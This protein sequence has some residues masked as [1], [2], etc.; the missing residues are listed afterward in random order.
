MLADNLVNL[1]H[2]M[3]FARAQIEG[4]R[5]CVVFDGKIH[6]MEEVLHI[7]KIPRGVRAETS[8]AGFQPF[9]KS[10]NWPNGQ[11]RARDV[12]QAQGDSWDGGKHH[13]LF[14]S[15]LSDAVAGK[16][17]QRMGARNRNL[18]RP[19]VAERGLEIDHAPHA[20]PHR[21]LRDNGATDHVRGAVFLPVIRI[22]VG[23]RSVNDNFGTKRSKHLLDETCIGNA[24]LDNG[25]SLNFRDNLSFAR[26][27]VVDNGNLVSLRKPVLNEV[28]A[29][30]ARPSGDKNPHDRLLLDLQMGVSAMHAMLAEII[31]RLLDGLG[32]RSELNLAEVDEG[33]TGIKQDGGCII[34]SEVFDLRF[35]IGLNL[36]GGHD[37][38]VEFLDGDI[39][40]AREVISI[41]TSAIECL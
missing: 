1:L 36:H 26:G 40:P 13:E 16:R 3:R 23:S 8:L 7:E 10:R 34:R 11:P 15:R 25:E 22:F 27:K 21:G 32:K 37:V 28:R 9:V 35:G 5:G 18:L 12:G 39:C 31:N 19:T 24:S 6:Q 29:K 41:T 2:G 33:P 38:V 14:S 30:A 17:G 20:M 4:A